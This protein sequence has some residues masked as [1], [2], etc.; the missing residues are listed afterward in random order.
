MICRVVD[1]IEDDFGAAAQESPDGGQRVVIGPNG[2]RVR[3]I[4]NIKVRPD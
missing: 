3:S 2:P 4:V 1:R